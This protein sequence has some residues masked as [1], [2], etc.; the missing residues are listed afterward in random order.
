MREKIKIT[1]YAIL[2]LVAAGVV[3]TVVTYG[4]VSD[5][6]MI[7]AFEIT[8]SHLQE[9]QIFLNGTYGDEFLT[10]SDK[11]ELLEY[12]TNFLGIS[13]KDCKIKKSKENENLKHTIS[14]R[15]D[16]MKMELC[17]ITSE[18]QKQVPKKQYLTM[19]ITFQGTMEQVLY[20]KHQ[21][22][23]LAKKLQLKEY[24]VFMNLKG[25][26]EGKLSKE[27]QLQEENKILQK[28]HGKKVFTVQDEKNIVWYG[29]TDLMDDYL[30]VDK[31]RINIHFIMTYDEKKRQTELYL[32]TPLFNEEY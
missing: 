23:K 14:F 24:Q 31:Q 18:N 11:R 4:F 15:K 21:M 5:E 27:E 16:S 32:A 30:T 25:T 1:I 10:E 2:V 6:R 28:L 29:Y 9:S 7:E 19:K 17:M 12:M 22:E 8:S 13:M 26:Y 20:Y 3:Q